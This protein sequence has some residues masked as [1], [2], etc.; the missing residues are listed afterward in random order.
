MQPHLIHCSFHKCL[1]KYY[2]LILG[3]LFNDAE[4]GQTG[5][6]H[7]DSRIDDF[8]REF[9]NYRVSS[10]NNRRL[11]FDRLGE[12]RITRFVRDPRDLVVSGYFYHK[13][14]AEGWCNIVGASTV[15]W[16]A[17]NGVAPPNMTETQSFAQLLEG[18]SQEDG[19][20]AEIDF[21]RA[22][23]ESMA[24][25]PMDHPHI[26][27]YRYEDILGREIEVF[28]DILAF[29]ELTAAEQQRGLEL[30]RQFAASSEGKLKSHIRD[31]KAG[32]WREVFTPTVAR[33]FEKQHL[34]LLGRYGYS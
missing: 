31:P 1:T 19:L 25:W 26:R 4:S 23:F 21:R 9:A 12:F 32:Q 7:F 6:R 14:G 27:T 24:Q 29:Y 20:I 15:N 5:Y 18:L 33:H 17:M 30:A 10:I 8:Y 34:A 28:S 3:G 16:S 11:D 22:H 2:H 13:R